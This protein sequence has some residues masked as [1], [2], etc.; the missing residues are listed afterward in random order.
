MRRVVS[1]SALFAALLLI[2]VSAFA[3]QTN[4]QQRN[5]AASSGDTGRGPGLHDS[6]A[7]ES[8]LL[9]TG[10]TLREV[11]RLESQCFEEVNRQRRGQGIR[12]LEFSQA[13]LPVARAYSRRMAEGGFFSHT[14]PEGRTIRH[15]VDEAGIK[16]T[17]LGENLASSNG[18]IN[19]VAVSMRGWMASVDHRRNILDPRYTHAAVGVWI[20]QD[21]TIYFTEIFLRE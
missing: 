1:L 21:S 8:K 14:D 6:R 7:D 9:A 5:G 15:R 13:L 17:T 4:S 2:L 18:Y 16:W 12:S 19:P 11:E 3:D 20:G 10:Y